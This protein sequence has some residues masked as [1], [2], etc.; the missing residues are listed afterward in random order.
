VLALGEQEIAVTLTG[1]GT[2][3]F[4]NIE[5]L[6]MLDASDFLTLRLY[7]NQDAGN[8]LWEYAFEHLI[9]DTQLAGYNPSSGQ[10]LHISADDPVVP[11]QA[12]ILGYASRNPATKTPARVRWHVNGHAVLEKYNDVNDTLGV[13]LN[14]ARLPS[15]AGLQAVVS[16]ELLSTGSGTVSL[17]PFIVVPGAPAQ[18]SIEPDNTP[19]SVEGVGEATYTIRATDQFGN[20]V[21]DGTGLSVTLSES[22][23]LVELDGAFNGGRARLR[24]KGGPHPGEAAFTVQVAD[25]A[26]VQPVVIHPL[27]FEWQ[28]DPTLFASARQSVELTVR[29]LNGQPAVGVPIQLGTTYGYLLEKELT[30][31]ADG[32]IHTTF[33]APN[34]KGNGE[35]TA[36]AGRSPLA[37]TPIEVV[38]PSLED[39][40]LEVNHATLIGDKTTAGTIT[41]TRYDNQ[42]I[43]IPY[44]V[45]ATIQVIGKEGD[46]VTVRIGD[47]GDPN[48]V[49]LA[50]YYLNAVTDDRVEDDTGR[51]HLHAAQVTRAPGT[52]LGGGHSLRF[53]ATQGDSYLFG[54]HLSGLEQAQSLGVS[55]EVLPMAGAQGSLVNFGQGALQL[56]FDGQHRLVYQLTTATDTHT[57]VSK[58]LMSGRWY[59]VAA[60]YHDGQM[61]LWIDG[62]ATLQTVQG[63]LKVQLA[64]NSSE[65]ERADPNRRH[66]L[67]IGKGFNGQLNSVK[68]VDWSGPPVLT[69]ADGSVETT[70]EIPA[71]VAQQPRAYVDLILISTGRMNSQGSQLALQRVAIHTSK[72]RQYASLLNT[73]GFAALAGVYAETLAE[74]APPINLAGLVPPGRRCRSALPGTQRACQQYLE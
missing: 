25:V 29:D 52:A 35:I 22:L 47:M 66:D 34:V 23:H 46:R 10:P 70:V 39:R 16:I 43:D 36:Q 18:I 63:A 31:N 65:A 69:F 73:A 24:I 51:H 72:V 38:Y 62:E 55:L 68:W 33:T 6:A 4:D 30:T 48:R 49:P 44:P 71:P 12:L 17:P 19:V 13:F 26:Q 9:L 41:H 3:R 60:R 1:N 2:I 27:Q 37:R 50:A 40:D 20:L 64:G 74:D 54:D 67:E 56:S 61:A 14:S 7:V 11:L 21:A 42:L 59:R 45:T 53:D 5:H 8:V 57:L 28:V 15:V 58:P 32:R